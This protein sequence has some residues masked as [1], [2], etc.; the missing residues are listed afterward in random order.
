LELS[1]QNRLDVFLFNCKISECTVTTS[2]DDGIGGNRNGNGKENQNIFSALDE[3]HLLTNVLCFSVI[4][5]PTVVDCLLRLP[6]LDMTVL[7]ITGKEPLTVSQCSRL[8]YLVQRSTKLKELYLMIDMEAPEQLEIALVSARHLN[9]IGLSGPKSS[10][11]NPREH[12]QNICDIFIGKGHDQAITRLLQDPHSQLKHL[13]LKHCDLDDDHLIAILDLLSTSRLETLDVSSNNI[14][15]HGVMEF[16]RR[17]PK[18]KSL[19][20]VCLADNPWQNSDN[21]E[22]CHEA[23]TQGMMHNTSIEY[24]DVHDCLVMPRFTGYYCNLN[25]LRR[26]ILSVSTPVPLGL[27]PRI[28]ERVKTAR[29]YEADQIY[30]LLQNSP[31][32][33]L[34][35]TQCTP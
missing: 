17:L 32:P 20:K 14:L 7:E 28:L 6:Q 31:I 13:H 30:F 23:L 18:I 21:T 34:D 5:S 16:A 33:T 22:E 11:S 24:L 1:N 8:G 25:F 19:T 29:K 27:W 2:Q 15:P 12:E 4:D 26:Y 9:I 3:F 10:W 35:T